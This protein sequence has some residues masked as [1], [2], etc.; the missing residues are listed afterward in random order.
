LRR[1]AELQP[2]RGRYAY[3][4][5]VALHSA[6]HPDE[7]MTVLKENLARHPNDR[8]TLVALIG[9]DRD[10][11]NFAEALQYAKQLAA[12]SPN[13]RDLAALI[14]DLSRRTK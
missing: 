3:V 14:S 11:G 5:A 7:A 1:A 6:G 8:D 9:F 12:I 2:E 13:D 4:L 10:A